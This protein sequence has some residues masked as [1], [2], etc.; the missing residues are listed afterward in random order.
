MDG[1][2]LKHKLKDDTTNVSEWYD[3]E[4]VSVHDDIVTIEYVGYT[5]TFEWEKEHMI[6]DIL[7]SD[8]IFL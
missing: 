7:N 4:V 1:R 3:G 2:K 5:D 6:E 8:L